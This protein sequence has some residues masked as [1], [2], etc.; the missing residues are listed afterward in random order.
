MHRAFDETKIYGTMLDPGVLERVVAAVMFGDPG[1]GSKMGPGGEV[2]AF[3]GRLRE[4]LRENCAYGD[5]VSISKC[6][7]MVVE[8]MLMLDCSFVIR[9]L[10]VGIL[11]II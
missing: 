7:G 8:D 4:R 6:L 11:R 5:P 9:K 3:E 2:K 10:W 1:F